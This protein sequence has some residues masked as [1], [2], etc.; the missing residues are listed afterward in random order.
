MP[1]HSPLCPMSSVW[2]GR[3]PNAKC[4]TPINWM[5]GLALPCRWSLYIF[6]ASLRLCSRNK[7]SCLQIFG[8]ENS[9]THL[10]FESYH[11]RHGPNQNIDG[12]QRAGEDRMLWFERL[13]FVRRIVHALDRCRCRKPK[14]TYANFVKC[15]PRLG[16]AQPILVMED[17]T[18][19]CGTK[20]MNFWLSM[21][22]VERRCCETVQKHPNRMRMRW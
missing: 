2:A 19:H 1:L 11:I 6:S 14:I 8:D 13:L 21:W 17:G 12:R 10:W 9:V 5:S 3:A 7:Y 18:W 15:T 22:H 20:N 16:R 4:N